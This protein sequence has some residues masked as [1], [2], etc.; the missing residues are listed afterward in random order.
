MI[1]GTFQKPSW[2]LTQYLKRTIYPSLSHITHHEGY[3]ELPLLI[4]RVLHLG[5]HAADVGRGSQVGCLF[6]H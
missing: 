5:E 3:L 2:I 4:T 6:C 1:L